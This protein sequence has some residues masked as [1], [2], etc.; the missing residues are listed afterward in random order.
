M[1]RKMNTARAASPAEAEAF[2]Q[3]QVRQPLAWDAGD[4]SAAVESPARRLQIELE[5]NWTVEAEQARWSPR[6]SLGFII[7]ASTLLWGALIWGVVQV[8]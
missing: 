7:I 3:P 1:V 8:V 2:A 5:R 6:R 4:G